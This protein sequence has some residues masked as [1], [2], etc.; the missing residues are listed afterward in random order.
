MKK[1]SKKR[2]KRLAFMKEEKWRRLQKARQKKGEIPKRDEISEEQTLPSR[3]EVFASINYLQYPELE[4]VVNNIKSTVPDCFKSLNWASMGRFWCNDEGYI[5]YTTK[6]YLMKTI[7]ASFRVV[8]IIRDADSGEYYA[9][10]EIYDQHVGLRNLKI[11]TAITANEFAKLMNANGNI[12]H[13][14]KEEHKFL[15]KRLD[16]AI[17]GIDP[18]PIKVF[19]DDGKVS[20]TMWDI[21]I[22]EKPLFYNIHSRSIGWDTDSTSGE[23][24]FKGKKIYRA[25][26][27][28]SQYVGNFK[29]E[30]GGDYEV[31]LD[32][33]QKEVLG[34]MYLEAALAFGASAVLKGYMTAIFGMSMNNPIVHMYSDSTNGKTTAGMLIVSMGGKPE[35]GRASECSLYCTF[36]GTAGSL[37]KSIGNNSGYPVCIDE[38]STSSMSDKERER[39]LYTLTGGDEKKRL[40]RDGRGSYWYSL[41]FGHRMG[42]VG[43]YACPCGFIFRPHALFLAFM[44]YLCHEW[45][46]VAS[47]GSRTF[48]GVIKSSDD[49]WWRGVWLKCWHF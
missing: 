14:P 20:A 25:T 44:G 19:S 7:G 39:I 23:L 2:E 12:V 43:G 38:L 16:D 29:V 32:M 40:K 36:E 28:F 27:E 30:E 26:D 45:V 48:T 41:V 15:M 3:K 49:S 31:Y 6:R 13:E 8:E 9:V 4:S 10:L 21:V 5:T 17:R 37:I 35:K 34:N 11:S 1:N 24:V 46:W 18:K 47:C 42:R 22:G 33:L